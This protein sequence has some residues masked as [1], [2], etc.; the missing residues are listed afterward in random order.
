MEDKQQWYVKQNG[1]ASGPYP[2]GL[3]RRFLLLQRIGESDEISQDGA[4]WVRLSTRQELI[5]EVMKA[6]R[7]DPLAQE[8][9]IKAR[10]WADERAPDDR[11]VF[12]ARGGEITAE[13]RQRADRRATEPVADTVAREGRRN[14]GAGARPRREGYLVGGLFILAVV[15]ALGAYLFY[16]QPKQ[17]G[18]VADCRAAP[19]PRVNW[20]SCRME[21]IA[22]ARADLTG[23]TLSGA[24]FSGGDFHGAVM[25]GANLSY[26]V[27]SLADFRGADLT[28]ANLKGVSLRSADLAHANLTGADLSY[29]DLQGANLTGVTLDGA[30]LDHAIWVDRAVC[31]PRSIGQ[32]LPGSSGN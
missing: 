7:D 22:L 13:Q 17:P 12:E 21:G 31:G 25:K 9:L 29:A 4:T 5:P 19:A 24:D 2:A 26:A 11:R 20:G 14:R 32:C 23:A 3:I 28:G 15:A 1:K 10:R 18:D 30:S 27:L 6:D 16:Y 8:R